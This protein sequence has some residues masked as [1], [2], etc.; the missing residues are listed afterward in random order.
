MSENMIPDRAAGN[1][2]GGRIQII[3]AVRGLSLCLM[4][5]HHFAIDLE[6]YGMFPGWFLYSKPIYVLHMI[7]ASVF[8]LLSGVSSRFSRSNVKRGLLVL[9][10]ALL[11]TVVTNLMNI[12]I[13]WGILHLLGAC[14]VLYGLLSRLLDRLPGAP[15]LVIYLALFLALTIYLDGR[16]FDSGSVFLAILGFNNPS[17]YSAD[18][19]PILPWIFMFLFGTVFGGYIRQGA[20]PKWFYDFDVR[21]FPAI[22]RK[23]LWIYLLHQPILYGLT[24]LLSRL[25]S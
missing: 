12:P 21:V 1:Y 7:F 11:V 10:C 19:F 20:L 24:L 17:F 5:L 18:Y 3:D 16:S 22:G 14:M 15:M 8:I 4:V 25:T 2:S 13:N 9:A 6:M 23:S